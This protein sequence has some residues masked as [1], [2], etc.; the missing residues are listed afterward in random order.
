MKYTIRI[1]LILSKPNLYRRIFRRNDIIHREDDKPA[2]EYS[3]G[4]KMWYDMG[5][6]MGY[7]SLGDIKKETNY[8]I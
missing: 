5:A 7:N 2:I 4:Q 8:E 6:F 1:S 3:D